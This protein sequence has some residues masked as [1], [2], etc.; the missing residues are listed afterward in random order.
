MNNE[1]MDLALVK[2]REPTA[3]DAV[4]EAAS[5][6]KEIS[7]L[8]FRNQAKFGEIARSD[9]DPLSREASKIFERML[10]RRV[11]LDRE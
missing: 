10:R 6:F 2:S 11:F 8:V 1:I 4:K 3:N 9:I 5:L 7:Q